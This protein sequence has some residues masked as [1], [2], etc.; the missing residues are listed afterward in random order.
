[1][2]RRHWTLRLLTRLA[3]SRVQMYYY[4]KYLFVFVNYH[5]R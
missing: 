3:L 1:M 5:K 2:S 4:R